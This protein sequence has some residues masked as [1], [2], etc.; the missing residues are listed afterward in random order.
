VGDRDF[1]AC[2]DSE[3][4]RRH[5]FT[6][7]TMVMPISLAILRS[8]E[9]SASMK[10]NRHTSAIGVT[11]LFMRAALTHFDKPQGGQYRDDLV[12]FENL[13]RH[14]QATWMD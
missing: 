6:K 9:V 8:N 5:D 4:I 13:D 7:Y 10:R 11:E 12:G 14:F 1:E 2:R 3:A